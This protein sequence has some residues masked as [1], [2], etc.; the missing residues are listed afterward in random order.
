MH[1][2]FV[3][4]GPRGEK[5]EETQKKEEGKRLKMFFLQIKDVMAAKYDHDDGTERRSKEKVVIKCYLIIL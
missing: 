4:L 1:N 3:N 2:K 5:N